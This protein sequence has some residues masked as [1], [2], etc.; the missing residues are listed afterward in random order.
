MDEK[1]KKVYELL[2]SLDI[3]YERYEHPAV[4]LP[5]S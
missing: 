2:D 1:E 3:E 4:Y 5:G